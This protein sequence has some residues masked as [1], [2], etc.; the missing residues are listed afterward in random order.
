MTCY[1]YLLTPPEP[2]YYH[3]SDGASPSL[4]QNRLAARENY[5]KLTTT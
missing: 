2:I 1:L 3:G 4:K 5:W